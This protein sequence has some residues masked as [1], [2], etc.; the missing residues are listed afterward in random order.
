MS[1]VSAPR[2]AC[3]RVATFFSERANRAT[4]TT[5]AGITTKV[6]RNSFASIT[7]QVASSASDLQPVLHI[8]G[9]RLRHR[10]LHQRHVRGE[11]REQLA[12]VPPLE[13]GRRLGKQP[14]VEEAPQIRHHPLPQPL[15]PPALEELGRGLHRRHRHHQQRQP[16][17]QLARRQLQPASGHGLVR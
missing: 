8:G 9:Q 10:E 16:A 14:R 11:A 3:E 17:Q 6:S 15:H 5:V 2:L 13:E 12:R 7:A 1:E 4:G